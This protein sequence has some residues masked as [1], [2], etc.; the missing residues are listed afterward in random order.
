MGVVRGREVLVTSLTT[1]TATAEALRKDL[2]RV[3]PQHYNNAKNIEFLQNYHRGSHPALDKREKLTRIDIDNKI[4]I[5]YAASITREI[6]GYFLGK[7]I[8]YT[9]APGGMSEEMQNLQYILDTA[10]KGVV[11][12]EIANDTS[13]CGVGYRGVFLDAEDDYSPISII[14]LDPASTFVVHSANPTKPPVYAVSFYDSPS[15]M[16]GIAA[17][18]TYTVYTRKKMFVF[19]VE[20]GGGVRHTLDDATLVLERD[21]DLGGSLPIIEYI[22]PFR[23]GDWELAIP[24]LDTIDFLASDTM[25]DI[26]QFVNSILAVI[27][28]ELDEETFARLSSQGLLNIANTN[29]QQVAVQY[30]SPSMQ[31]DLGERVRDYFEAALR[32]VVGVPDRKTRGGGGGDTGDAVFMRDGWHDIDLVASGK[33]PFFIE[34]ERNSLKVI[35]YLLNITKDITDLDSHH[36]KVHFNRNKT[37]NVQ[38][39]ATTFS[40]LMSSGLDPIDALDASNIF[41]NNY[42]VVKRMLEYKE[43]KMEEALAIAAGG[44]DEEPTE[45][46]G[47]QEVKSDDE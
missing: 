30:L 9:Y 4:E 41:S 1:D 25:N 43:K 28:A 31:A 37:A 38:S 46:E 20:T 14:R 47:E 22:N 19:E 29:G 8:Q 32:V 33:E 11:D 34:S 24:I 36:I 6:V 15:T 44:S 3:L 17:K 18:T 10:N 26:E 5:N 39:K 35:L 40:T 45:Q 27:G 12:I 21:V 2:T 16:P 13:I 42:D 23:M 7:P